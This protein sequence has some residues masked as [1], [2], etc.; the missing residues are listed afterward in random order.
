[1]GQSQAVTDLMECGLLGTSDQ[2]V[3]VWGLIIKLGPEPV[4]RNNRT[5][6]PYM[7]QAID[8]FKDGDKEIHLGNPQ[9]TDGAMT[10]A[11]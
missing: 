8:I 2:E 9:D 5:L 4:E 1:M 11:I 7:S 10:A 3:A 6:T